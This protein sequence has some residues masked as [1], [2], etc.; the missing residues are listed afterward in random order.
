MKSFIQSTYIFDIELDDLFIAGKVYYSYLS[1]Y[2]PVSEHQNSELYIDPDSIKIY[3]PYECM[4]F[5]EGSE[6]SRRDA[7]DYYTS[8]LYTTILPDLESYIENELKNLID[9]DVCGGDYSENK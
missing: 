8:Y 6:V 1:E 3:K 4:Y 5:I 9:V 2:T 7:R